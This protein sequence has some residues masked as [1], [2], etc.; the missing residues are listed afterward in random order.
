MDFYIGYCTG[1]FEGEGYIY[2]TYS[3]RGSSVTRSIEFGIRM[4]DLYPLELFRDFM[5]V[6]SITGPFKQKNPNH[7]DFYCYSINTITDIETAV[8]KLYNYLSPRRMQQCDD[9]IT[10]Y[11]EWD[12]L[13]AQNKPRYSPS[14]KEV[15]EIRLKFVAGINQYS[16]GEYGKGNVEELATLYGVSRGT[17][18]NIVNKKF[19]YKNI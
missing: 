1:L 17:I 7:T 13:Y 15:D 5:D 16:T 9:A 2:T 8:E 18:Y 11:K 19:K 14:Q 4:C 3:D 6:G 10:K 12:S